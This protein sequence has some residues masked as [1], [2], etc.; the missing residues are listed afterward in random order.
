MLKSFCISSPLFLALTS[1]ISIT[2]A[3]LHVTPSIFS[4]V[5]EL[6]ESNVDTFKLYTK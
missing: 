5:L 1:L 2:S 3:R 6:L 4:S